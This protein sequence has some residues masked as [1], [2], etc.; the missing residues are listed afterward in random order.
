MD[1]KIV[2]SNAEDDEE[3]DTRS[4]INSR[5]DD[6]L[7]C[8]NSDDMTSNIVAKC[9]HSLV[10]FYW[11]F[12]LDNRIVPASPSPMPSMHCII[13]TAI[14]PRRIGHK[15]HLYL[16]SQKTTQIPPEGY[17]SQEYH[18]REIYPDQ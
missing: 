10:L 16:P 3:C 9:R 2:G 11:Q 4:E 6:P 17:Y 12:C 8:E 7:K 1:T 5:I 13:F 14:F 18:P 15:Q